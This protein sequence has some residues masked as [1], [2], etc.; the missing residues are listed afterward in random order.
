MLSNEAS[1]IILN[2]YSVA[3]SGI[4]PARG[5]GHALPSG[6][7]LCARS[8]PPGWPHVLRVLLYNYDIF[9]S[10][11]SRVPLNVRSVT[12]TGVTYL[13]IRIRYLRWCRQRW[14]W[15]DESRATERF[16][17]T[18]KIPNKSKFSKLRLKPCKHT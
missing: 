7:C 13:S 11:A 12:V 10:A 14:C 6:H 17:L 3:G 8:Q 4:E 1:G 16:K 18:I 15:K 9:S 2:V 5:V